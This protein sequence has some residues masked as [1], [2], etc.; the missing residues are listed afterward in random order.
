MAANNT[1]MIFPIK[2]KAFLMF[3]AAEPASFPL[4]LFPQLPAAY[5]AAI[6]RPWRLQYS[7][8][9]TTGSVVLKTAAGFCPG[10][11]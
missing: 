7:Y 3:S 2:L 6:Q 4:S 1:D 11:R 5:S 8:A 10:F 9:A